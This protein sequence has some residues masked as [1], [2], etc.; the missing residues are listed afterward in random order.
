MKK[1]TQEDRDNIEKDLK[2][3]SLAKVDSEYLKSRA[4]TG[5]SELS[6][7][8]IPTPSLILI[9]LN[10][11][12]TDKDEKPL[13]RGMFYYKGDGSLFKEVTC[14]LLTFTK[15][16]FP[17]YSDKS[18]MVKTYVFLG[19]IIPELKPFVLY[20]K[21]TGIGAAKQFFGQMTSMKVPMFA[22]KVRLTSD[23]IESEKGTYWKINFHIDGVRD[24]MKELVTLETLTKKYESTVKTEVESEVEAGDEPSSENIPFP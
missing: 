2:E 21:S 12:I 13:P 7:D 14:S 24:S 1:L 9:Q 19:A 22:L 6:Q 20:L 16:D 3:K 11:A 10:S 8:D 18:K 17:D 5:L 23:K 4:K 15:K